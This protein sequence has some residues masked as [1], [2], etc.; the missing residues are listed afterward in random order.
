MLTTVIIASIKPQPDSNQCE[1]DQKADITI[2]SESSNRVV[3]EIDAPTD[4][5]LVLADVWYPGWE[6]NVN[7]ADVEIFK[8]D[9]LFRGVEVVKGVNVVEFVYRPLSFQLGAVISLFAWVGLYLG[10]RKWK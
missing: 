9:Y 4:G 7:G 10:W 3:L 5:W 1:I 2:I 6:S 8:A